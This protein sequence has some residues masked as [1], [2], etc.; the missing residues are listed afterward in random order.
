MVWA[1]RL[2]VYLDECAVAVGSGKESHLV[3]NTGQT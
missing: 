1:Y 2:A 3:V